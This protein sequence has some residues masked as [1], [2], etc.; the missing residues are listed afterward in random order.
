[1]SP[2]AT[3]APS[4][5]NGGGSSTNS[6]STSVFIP[7]QTEPVG[8]LTFT[9]PP[10]SA[11]SYYKIA[12]NNV[13]TFGWSFTD[14]LVTP[15]HL[16]VSAGCDNSNTYPIGPTNGVIDGTATTVVW[17]IFSYQ[18][19]NPQLPLA[20]GTC[21]LSI[22]DDRGP[23]ATEQPGFLQPNSGL[24]FALYTPE[25]YTPLASGW[26]CPE[27]NAGNYATAPPSMVAV[28]ILTMVLV[29]VI[30]GLSVLRRR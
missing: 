2:Q 12:T 14:V 1:M 15:T 10:Q 13:I 8:Q 17:D 26:T 29:M 20:P 21:T 23:T 27:C 16:T 25:A 6:T 3:N 4:S 19:N 5:S 9:Q 24:R 28:S 22:W 30:S 11:T 18:T 7:N